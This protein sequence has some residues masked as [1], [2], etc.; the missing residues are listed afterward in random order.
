MSLDYPPKPRWHHG[1]RCYL[2]RDEAL[3]MI[4]ISMRGHLKPVRTPGGLRLGY[5]IVHGPLLLLPWTAVCEQDVID[6][7][8]FAPEGFAWVN[9]GAKETP[10]KRKDK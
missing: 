2:D 6:K 1:L 8:K 4:Q 9:L 5:E 3:E 7:K 10:T